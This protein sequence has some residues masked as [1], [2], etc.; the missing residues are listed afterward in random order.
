MKGNLRYKDGAWRLRVNAGKDP[1]TGKPIVLYRTVREPNT[2]DG[3]RRAETELA[4]LVLE[5]EARRDIPA[6][7]PTVEAWMASWY[8]RASPAWAPS[9]R[10]TRPGVIRKHIVAHL[11]DQRIGDLRRR[12]IATWHQTLAAAGLSPSSV[13]GA[14][15]ILHRALADA[16]EL[17]VIDRNPASG[18]KVA[19]STQTTVRPPTDDEL[20]AVLTAL[21]DDPQ[22]LTIVQVD[23]VLGARRGE[24]CALRWT[25]LDFDTATITVGRAISVGRQE[26]MAERQTKTGKVRTVGLDDATMHLLRA[27]R[28]RRLEQC[29]AVGARMDDGGFVFVPD[30]DPTGR[31]PLR[32]TL[33]SRR[34]LAACRRAGVTGVRFHDLRHYVASWLLRDG[35]DVRST[36]EWLGHSPTMTLERYGHFIP[37]ENR[38]AA[39]RLAARRKRSG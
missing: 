33:V 31:S 13:R 21:A 12:D 26:G 25:D 11:G 9:T 29:L 19:G 17:E 20:D 2:R 4:R 38:S 27:H 15:R 24:L 32:P 10:A 18:V 8:T 28:V 37:P 3:K 14:H 39:E 6:S 5:A 22:T 30:A 34:F 1:A 36:A 16:V 35:L 23:A 7:S